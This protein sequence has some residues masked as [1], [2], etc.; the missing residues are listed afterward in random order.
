M[1][2]EHTFD[3]TQTPLEAHLLCYSCDYHDV[4]EALAAYT[5]QTAQDKYVIG[6][7]GV[8]FDLGEPNKALDSILKPI[9]IDRIADYNNKPD[10]LISYNYAQLNITDLVP[11]YQS[12]NIDKSLTSLVM[13][14][15]S[16]T[17]FLYIYLT[18][19]SVHNI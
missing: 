1:G 16:L 8:L 6:V 5:G 18:K 10:N 12:Q 3:N 13:Y 14:Y 2:S 4:R 15:G 9:I 19:I 7:I 17:V 11:G